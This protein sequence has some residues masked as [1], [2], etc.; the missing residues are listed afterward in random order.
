MR[1]ELAAQKAGKDYH[2]RSRLMMDAGKIA[3][4]YSPDYRD[5]HAAWIDWPWKLHR[6]QSKKK[7]KQTVKF[8]LY[9]LD[10]DPMES[11]DLIESE[12][13]RT[14]AMQGDLDPWMTSVIASL[15]GEDYK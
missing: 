9:R 11:R 3:K 15:N 1:E 10:D 8:E 6:M 2:D 5:G 13:A 4:R 14:K 12:P 7:Q